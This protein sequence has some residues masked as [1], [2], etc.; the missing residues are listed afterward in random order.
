MDI[1]NKH[2]NTEEA[3]LRLPGYGRLV[4]QMV[5]HAKNIEDRRERTAYARRIIGVM[6]AVGENLRHEDNYE[7]KL[8]NHLALISHYELDIDYPVPVRREDEYV[9]EDKL[10]YPGNVIKYRHY[11]RLVEQLI[12][13]I[14]EMPEG[15]QRDEA[16]ATVARRMCQDLIQWRG[17]RGNLEERVAGDLEE[18][19]NGMV[20]S[21]QVLS[22]LSRQPAPSRR[23]RRQTRGSRA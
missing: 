10:T 20:R 18:Y 9:S 17:D 2:Y 11:G 19:T 6:E 14:V 15:A 13:K 16:I 21:G 3:P 1:S 5:E 4:T 8:W 7:Q 22:L 12:E 23:G